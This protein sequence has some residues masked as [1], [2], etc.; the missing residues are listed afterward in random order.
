[1]EKD[2]MDAAATA[3]QGVQAGAPPAP[4]MQAPRRPYEAPELRAVGLGAVFADNEYVYSYDAADN[5]F[6][7]SGLF[8]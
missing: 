3:A 8:D 4:A 7:S 2:I 1:M 5:D 6:S